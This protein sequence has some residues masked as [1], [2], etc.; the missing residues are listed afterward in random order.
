MRF[1]P[2]A[3]VDAVTLDVADGSVLA[4]LGPS[5]CGKSTLL[6]AVAGIEP[7]VGGSVLWDDV[8]LARIPLHRRRFGLMFQDG[9]LFPHRTVAGNV[10]YGLRGRPDAPD[11][12]AELL[13]MVGL[14]GYQDRRVVTL[15]G[16]EAQRVALARALAPRPLLLLLDEPLAALDRALRDQ[17]LVDLKTVL[18]ATGTT[19]I[20]VTHDQGEAFA[21]ADRIALMRSGRIVQ[22]GAPQQVWQ[23]PRDAEAARFLGCGAVIPGWPEDVGGRCVTRTAVGAVPGRAEQVGLRPATLVVDPAGTIAATVLSAVPGP[24]RQVLTVRI[25]ARVAGGETAAHDAVLAETAFPAV[26]AA[27]SDLEVGQDIRLRFDPSQTARVGLP[28][29]RHASAERAAEP[30]AGS[31]P[32][33]DPEPAADVVVAGAVTAG[34]RLLVARRTS[35]PDL[36]GKWELPGGKV[37]PGESETSALAR[38]LAEELGIVAEV[39][40]RVGPAI[41]LGT[42]PAGR[43][44]ELHAYRAEVRSGTASYSVHDSLRWVGP[45]DLGA[46]DWVPADRQLV[47]ELRRLLADIGASGGVGDVDALRDGEGRLGGAVTES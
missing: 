38:E 26:A 17:L 8:D 3:A 14:A 13:A 33:P 20:F 7:P 12:V 42:T 11:R 27:G 21:V 32:N 28:A 15:S 47:P 44:L 23:A 18:A 34:G 37:D 43:P 45:D 4:L 9:V 36:A 29:A 6:R 22:T 40:V 35:P 19:A 24:E 1:G 30:G 5:G 39:G 41:T 25:D 10:G 31:T 2:V 46:L 16:G